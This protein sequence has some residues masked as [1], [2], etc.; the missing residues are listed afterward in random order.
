MGKEQRRFDRIPETFSARCR[1][2]GSLQEP[3]R[4]VVTLDLGAGGMSL[5]SEQLFDAEDRVDIEMRLPGILEGL[6][7]RGRVVRSRPLAPGTVDVAV[8]FLDVTPD[9]QARIDE[10][11][12]FLKKPTHPHEPQA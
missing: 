10:L 11:V 12:Q 3:W 4:S 9:E 2:A 7:L 6:I 8:E 1:P 5:Q